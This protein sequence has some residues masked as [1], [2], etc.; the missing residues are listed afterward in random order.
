MRWFS[1]F[2]LAATV[3]ALG[4][5]ACGDDVQVV[6]PTPPVPDRPP[7]VTATMAPASASVAVGNS[8]VF[9]ANV[10]GGVAGNAASWT[11]TS[12]NTGIA[13]VSVVST[14][15]QATGV[16]AGGVTI[17][18]VVSKSGESVNVGAQLT[19]TDDTEPP[20][21]PGDPAFL[22]VASI[23]GEDDSASSGLK[24]R[25]SVT[26]NVERGDQTLEML[27]LLV[28][29]QVVAS[30]SF[31]ESMGMTPPEDEAAEQAVHAFTLGFD[32]HDYDR[33][34]GVPV[35]TNGEHT[36][37]AELEIVVDMADGTRGHETIVS[38]TVTAEFVNEDFIAA[39]VSGL[40][41]GVMNANTG[42]VWYGGPDA[43][44]GI[45][46]LPVL[47]SNGPVSSVTL[48]SFCGNTAATDPEAPFVFELDCGGWQT[49]AANGDTPAFNI[50]GGGI[51]S[52][53]GAVHLDFKAPD[54]PHFH[55]NPNKREDGWVNG[56]VNF[57]G[58]QGSGS[59]TNGWL[60][61][62]ETDAREGVGGYTPQIRFAEVGSDRKVGGALAVPPLAQLVLPP[63]LA[64]R[65]SRA[66][67]FCVVVSATD[68][69]GN[70]SKLPKVDADCVSHSDY[71]ATDAAKSAG[72]L[73]GVDLQDPTITFS[74]ASPKANATTMRNFQ[75][76]IA[77]AASGIRAIMPL[78]TEVMLRTADSDET[79]KDL[80]IDISLPLATT[81]DLPDGVGYYT[82][83]ATVSDKAGNSSSEATRTAL[84]DNEAPKVSAVVGAYDENTGEY[85]LL[86]T[87][88]DNLSIK[89]YWPEMRFDGL[90]FGNNMTLAEPVLLS[91]ER[92][93]AYNAST[94][95]QATL[96]SSLKVPSYRAVQRAG[97]ISN[98]MLISVFASDHGGNKSAAAP[99]NPTD[100]T[101][102]DLTVAND[103]FDLTADPITWG[104]RSLF[105]PATEAD[106]KVFQTIV[107]TVDLKIGKIEIDLTVTGTLFTAP[108][109]G[110]VDDPNTIGVNEGRDG[111][112]GTQ[113]LKD[114]P[115]S[116]IDIYASVNLDDDTALDGL[117]YI[118]SVSA[119]SADAEYFDSDPS[120]NDH[121]P[122]SRRFIYEMEISTTD[123]LNIVGDGDY[124][125]GDIV[126]FGV[127]DNKG[128]AI[129]A[130]AVNLI[131]TN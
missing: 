21:P 101:P 78:D 117:E 1:R 15:C 50:A 32:S 38:N 115:L 52:R 8:V 94:L 39:T 99:T 104:T 64:G 84:H 66:D 122:D 57:T 95:T 86:A 126:V 28:D 31:G 130:D 127:R 108:M 14:G 89:E 88:T 25:V 129:A 51:T 121:A 72:L 80:D 23:K 11:C 67:A 79:I 111:T 91:R 46:A 35:Y 82:F 9:A 68:K 22:L 53:G 124:Y 47:Y 131:V 93:D 100:P 26:L 103:G 24:G 81:T 41:E 71:D 42:R 110:V 123:F 74:P 87:V 113:G 58:E 112:D 116:R 19:V 96:T 109:P 120:D 7:P 61:Y 20:P 107:A 62:N 34:S 118:M 77:D 29:G 43:S 125:H 45:R 63:T 85:A 90:T 3:L 56:S 97:T 16:A 18:A 75:V 128:V 48:L 10:S 92:V 98:L 40:G 12:S 55:V 37:S 6:E 59:K 5:A 30:Q 114:N 69:L 27:S 73:A 54:A 33:E 2:A 36:I 17:T 105:T 106:S 60:V 76:Q 119:A 65:S 49:V 13:T 4:A 102:I 83:S 70:E 44:V